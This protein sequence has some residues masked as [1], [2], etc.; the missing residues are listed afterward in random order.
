[1]LLGGSVGRI[2]D[3]TRDTLYVMLVQLDNAI[4]V[5]Y[6]QSACLGVPALTRF[7]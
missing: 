4:A 2:A 6:H 7:S 5:L 1:M 3:I